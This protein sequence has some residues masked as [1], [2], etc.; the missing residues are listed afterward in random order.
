MRIN[1]PQNF[2][3]RRAL[4]EVL[5]ERLAQTAKSGH[6]DEGDDDQ[7]IYALIERARD[8]TVIASENVRGTIP[9]ANPQTAWRNGVKAAA[10]LLAALDSLER[11]LGDRLP[12]E[13]AMAD[14]FSGQQ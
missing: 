10:T 13:Q 7:P 12:P 14:L 11:R 9:S 8:Y 2:T 6:G 4:R 3:E 1:Q 5:R